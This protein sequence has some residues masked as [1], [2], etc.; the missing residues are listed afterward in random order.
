MLSCCLGIREKVAKETMVQVN[1]QFK[2][3]FT[4][5]LQEKRVVGMPHQGAV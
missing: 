3:A 4:Q 5:F 2:E 1:P